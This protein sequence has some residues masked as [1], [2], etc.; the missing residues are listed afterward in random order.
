MEFFDRNPS[1]PLCD[2]HNHLQDERIAPRLRE[3]LTDLPMSNVGACVVNGT[4]EKDWPLVQKL[5][6]H[7]WVCPAFGLHPWF[8]KDRS[9]NWLD[10]LRRVLDQ[11]TA[12]RL[13]AIGEI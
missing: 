6:H 8:A 3:L 9:L 12:E 4:C 7:L 11:A 2:A 10:S 1:Q 13:P 5:G